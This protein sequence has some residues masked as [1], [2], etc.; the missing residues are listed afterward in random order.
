MAMIKTK[1]EKRKIKKRSNTKL[2][3]ELLW[4]KNEIFNKEG[5]FI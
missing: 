3:N 5:I 2:L 4:K 1:K